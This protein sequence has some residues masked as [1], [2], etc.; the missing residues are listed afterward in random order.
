MNKIFFRVKG[1]KL[2][3]NTVSTEREDILRE[4]IDN[5][6]IDEVRAEPYKQDEFV[7]SE[8]YT[9]DVVEDILGMFDRGSK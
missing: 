1:T 2:T 7:R 4:I 5:I 3:F 8:P 9:P 6:F